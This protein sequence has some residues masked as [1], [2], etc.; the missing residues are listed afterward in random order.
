MRPNRVVSTVAFVLLLV[1]GYGVRYVLR[2][3]A[4]DVTERQVEEAIDDAYQYTPPTT[5]P[6]T[7]TTEADD[8]P[9]SETIPAT[10]APVTTTTEAANALPKGWPAELVLVDGLVIQ[11]TSNVAGLGVVGNLKGDLVSVTESIRADLGGAGFTVDAL[12]SPAPTGAGSV[13]QATGPAGA[14]SVLISPSPE[15]AG[16]LLVTYRLQT[17]A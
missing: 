15:A 10:T 8:E 5:R 13:T 7:A 14:L 17:A 11:S 4:S 1:A 16:T 12:T 3:A 2:Q 6:I 9:R